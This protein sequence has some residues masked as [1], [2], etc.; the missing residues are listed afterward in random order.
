MRRL[1]HVAT[2]TAALAG[3]ATVL[4]A[5]AEAMPVQSGA[6]VSGPVAEPIFMNCTRYWNGWRWV[7]RCV[8]VVP[9]YGYGAYGPAYGYYGYGPYYGYGYG[10][11][12]RRRFW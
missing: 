9:E 6:V 8:D 3:A 11:G 12:W 1:I 4:A 10:Y 5:P 7:R 2:V